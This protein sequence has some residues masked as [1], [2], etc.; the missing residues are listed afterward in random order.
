M[1]FPRSLK[2]WK[3]LKPFEV[4]TLCTIGTSFFLVLVLFLLFPSIPWHTYRYNLAVVWIRMLMTYLLSFESL[5]A[6]QCHDMTE[7]LPNCFDQKY[8]SS[9]TGFFN[10]SRTTN[11]G[12]IVHTPNPPNL[13]SLSFEMERTA[14]HD[15]YNIIRCRWCSIQMD[16]INTKEKVNLRNKQF[17]LN[18]KEKSQ[19]F[20]N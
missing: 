17:S 18:G 10:F 14:Q 9:Q 16:F 3:T 19:Q 12:F 2:C 20:Q 1:Y 5:S 7:V 4:C 8:I 13:P 6:S 15:E 11:Q